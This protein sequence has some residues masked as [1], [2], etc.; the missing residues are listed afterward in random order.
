VI[1][2]CTMMVLGHTRYPVRDIIRALAGEAIPGASFTVVT[3]RLP[4][5]LSGLFAG[6]AFGM[7]GTVFQTILR[8]PLANP[9]SIGISAGSSAAAA[10]CI[11]VL[12]VDGAAVSLASLLG[13]L[14][15]V[16]LIFLLSRKAVFSV[17]RLIL[18]GIGVQIM[19][20]ALISYLL[21]AGAEEDV[22][23]VF[24]WLSGSLNGMRIRDCIPLMLTVGMAAPVLLLWGNRLSIME[25]GEEAAS[26]LGVN[27]H[28]TR[29]VMFSCAVFLVAMATSATGPLSFVAF[30]SGPIAKRLVGSGR[31]G[32]LP[33]GL[34][35]TVLVLG[36]DLLGQFAWDTRFPAGVI[37][38]IL[39]APYLLMLLIR[40][41]RKGDL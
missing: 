2:C 38:G 28:K 24:R 22:P 41:N 27:P 12:H 29:I 16:G 30:L 9:N 36:A 13:G 18:S 1:L 39:G 26:T 20:N 14:S 32:V 11:L 5:M 10:F 15:T 23:R 35:G 3:L 37:T 7:A 8:N 34:T 25:L 33:A 17:G 4:R 21:L 31:S 40:M 19:L 6:L